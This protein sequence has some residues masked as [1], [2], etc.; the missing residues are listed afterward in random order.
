MESRVLVAARKFRELGAA[1]GDDIA[2]LESI[3]EVPRSLRPE[4]PPQDLLP[5]RPGVED[6]KASGNGAENQA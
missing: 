4:N 2:L 3:D 5:L 1:T 6:E